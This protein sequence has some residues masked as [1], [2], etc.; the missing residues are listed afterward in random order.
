MENKLKIQDFSV[1]NKT[2]FIHISCYTEYDPNVLE[3]KLKMLIDNGYENIILPIINIRKD[4]AHF[5]NLEF[6]EFKHHYSIDNL[7]MNKNWKKAKISFFLTYGENLIK[8]IEL[9]SKILHK[10]KLKYS[11]KFCYENKNLSIYLKKDLNKKSIRSFLYFIQSISLKESTS[12]LK[13]LRKTFLNEI[14]QIMKKILKKKN[15][16]LFISERGSKLTGNLKF[17][18]DDLQKHESIKTEI[19]SSKESFKSSSIKH[20][21]LTCVK[22]AKSEV[23]I[24]DNYFE[25]INYFNFKNQFVLQLWHACGAFKTFG[26]TRAGRPGAP[27]MASSAHRKYNN[28]IVSSTNVVNCYAEAF[29]VSKEVVLPLGIPRTDIFF[30]N[31]YSKSIKDEFYKKYPN[32]KNKKIIL[33]APTFRG[34]RRETAYYPI[35]AFNPVK[36][37]NRLNKEYVIVLKYHLFIKESFKVPEE[38]SDSIIS[39]SADKDINDLLFI[40]DIVITDYSSLIFES[41]LLNLPMLFYTFDLDSYISKRG[42]YFEYNDFVPGKIVYSQDELIESIKNKDFEE[43]KL[44]SFKNKFFDNLDGKSTERVSKLILDKI[45]K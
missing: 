43:F 40:A 15:R 41:S 36:I 16:V 17:V 35:D 45:K 21:I 13:L 37:Y 6:L 44:K 2:I 1:K 25:P 22:M 38:Y 23:I 3:P 18:Y 29:G 4:K 33:F 30:D 10:K 5:Q 32:L 31:S 27:D 42:F 8:N 26:F 9:D 39:I 12:N 11:I 7:F 24:L 14:Y 20:K 28:V 19:S 34:G